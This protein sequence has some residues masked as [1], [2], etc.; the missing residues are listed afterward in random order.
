MMSL[1]NVLTVASFV[2]MLTFVRAVSDLSL[3]SERMAYKRISA[4]LA[5]GQRGIF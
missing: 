5:I 2:A 4:D 1:R 3:A